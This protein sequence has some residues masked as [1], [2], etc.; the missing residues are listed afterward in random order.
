MD[1]IYALL[2]P[3]LTIV[4][5]WFWKPWA[6]AYAGEKGKN[7]ARKEDLEQILAEVR[8]V[9]IT[10]REIEAKI[11]GDMWERQWRLNQKR[12]VYTSLLT[13]LHQMELLYAQ[14][15]AQI[16]REHADGAASARIMNEQYSPRTI[17]IIE[18]LRTGEALVSIFCENN[19]VR[20]VREL[21][22][23][24]GPGGAVEHVAFVADLLERSREQLLAAA[25]RELG[26]TEAPSNDHLDVGDRG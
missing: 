25:R 26:V 2:S 23:E 5:L 24:T 13:A 19:T 17:E 16:Q 9:T 4:F 21:M 22:A 11:S 7:L 20:I 3:A 18:K 15:R 12:D 6:G 10:Q 14:A 8:A 1:I